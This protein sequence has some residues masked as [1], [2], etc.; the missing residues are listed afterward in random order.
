ML[1]AQS[2]KSKPD[3]FKKSFGLSVAVHSLIFSLFFIKLVFFSEPML[4]LSQAI[5]VNVGDFKESN[6]LPPKV[7]EEAPPA[8]VA[9]EPTPEPQTE[10][11]TPKSEEKV[12]EKKPEP[13]PVV[14]AKETPKEK[15]KPN[16]V[17][18]DKSKAKQKSALEKLKK[19][20]ALDKIKQ[21]VQ[22]EANKAKVANAIKNAKPRAVAAG[23]TLTG[24]DKLQASNYLQYVDKSIKQ[25]WALPQW[26]MN[27]P[28]KARILVKFNAQGQII[29]TQVVSPSGNTSYDQYCIN[30]IEKAAP[31]PQVPEKLTEKF[32]ADGV[33]VG[34]P[35]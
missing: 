11:P 32:S 5:T 24:L 13:P 6:R 4:D 22:S 29:S 14:K 30:A 2:Q 16:E 25:Q 23:S 10:D 9:E 8:P 26:L 31:F 1:E 33:V 19:L 34:F 28:L 17:N 7:I 20:S 15:P 3:D 18:L 27:K 21:D 12:S 35:E